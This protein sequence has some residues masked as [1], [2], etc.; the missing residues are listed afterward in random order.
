MK[1]LH[2]GDVAVMRERPASP[3]VLDQ[4]GIPRVYKATTANKG[5]VIG[6][7]HTPSG[8]EVGDEIATR[9]TSSTQ[10]EFVPIVVKGVAKTRKAI[11][12]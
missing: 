2:C 3:N 12:T 10:D 11:R 5:R 6:I 9:S 4:E 8:K 1:T 7:V